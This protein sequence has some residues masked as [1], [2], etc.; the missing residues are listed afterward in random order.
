VYKTN[1]SPQFVKETCPGDIVQ[2]AEK[3]KTAKVI[4]WDK[5]MAT[6]PEGD[7]VT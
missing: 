3:G 6:D 4:T 7:A 1:K 5:P 2:Y